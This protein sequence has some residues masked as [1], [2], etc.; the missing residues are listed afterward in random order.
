MVQKLAPIL[1]EEGIVVGAC[2]MY[3]AVRPMAYRTDIWRAM[4]LWMYGGLYMDDKMALVEPLESWLDL[5]KETLLLPMDREGFFD[6]DLEALDL[7]NLQL[8]NNSKPRAVWNGFMYSQPRHLFWIRILRRIAQQVFLK[9]YPHLED[10]LLAIT[11][12]LAYMHAF[13]RAPK[14]L[15]VTVRRDVEISGDEDNLKEWREM[16]LTFSSY[17]ALSSNTSRPLVVQDVGSK[18]HGSPDNPKH[19]AFHWA[20][21]TI[22]CNEKL[23]F[24][25]YPK[26]RR[27][28]KNFP[29]NFQV[30]RC[31]EA[32]RG[33]GE[34]VKDMCAAPT[35]RQ[36]AQ[37]PEGRLCDRGMLLPEVYL[38]GAM[39]FS[40]SQLVHDW[41]AAG[42]YTTTEY[43]ESRT[44]LFFAK[45]F[46]SK[47][48][49]NTWDMA[50]IRPVWYNSL[51]RC[52]SHRFPQQG[53]VVLVDTTL[54]N[55]RMVPLPVNDM[56][57][58]DKKGISQ[59]LNGANLTEISVA[60]RL[61]QLYGSLSNRVSFVVLLHNPLECLR[62][63]WKLSRLMPPA[64]RRYENM[65]QPFI[66]DSFIEE[67]RQG[68]RAVQNS[69]RK[70]TS[71]LWLAMFGEQIQHYLGAFAASQFLFAPYKYYKSSAREELQTHLEGR[72]EMPL[73]FTS[74]GEH[75]WQEV[76]NE[77]VLPHNL[78]REFQ[79]KFANK[80]IEHLEKVLLQA[81]NAGAKLLAFN[82]ANGV[83]AELSHVHSWLSAGW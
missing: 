56:P 59:L 64:Q 74:S 57:A 6:K 53:R 42:M 77:T 66:A 49:G 71:L 38:L 27:L 79:I 30:P 75:D 41:T 44:H 36:I 7:E 39:G 50:T 24:E 26:Q 82:V 15:Q 47:S 18:I 10:G 5:E 16:N 31:D 70:I 20:H 28:P 11:G 40:M 67:L 25:K 54:D 1:E 37:M 68:V 32:A 14:E 45:Y 17:L 46:I 48:Y 35:P 58:K 62:F 9:A 51:P 43:S 65:L 83:A 8:D 81:H 55:L 2:E 52:T 21:H 19:Y 69:P 78:V 63:A 13:Y 12:P 3:H 34:S 61:R 33:R 4:V 23:D 76:F 29:K 60:P 22:Y 72:L 80:E 73:K